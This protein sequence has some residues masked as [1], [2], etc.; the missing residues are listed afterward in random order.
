MMTSFPVCGSLLLSPLPNDL[1]F[2]TEKEKLP[3]E[4]KTRRIQKYGQERTNGSDNQ[5]D[6]GVLLRKETGID[7]SIQCEEVVANATKLPL[8]SNSYSNVVK[9]E[10]G[11]V[12]ASDNFM[13]AN[14]VKEESFSDLGK[15]ETLGALSTSSTCQEV[16]ANAMK[17]PFLS[18]SYSNVIKSE[19][20]TVRA[21]DNSMVPHKVKGESFSDLA[22]G[23]TLEALTTQEIGSVEKPCRT[24]ASGGKVLEDKKANIHSDV[25]A[26]PRK[27][28]SFKGEK[29]DCFAKVDSNISKGRKARNAEHI[30]PLEQK[31]SNKVTSHEETDMHVASGK[32][33]SSSGGV[34]KLK[35]SQSHGAQG[36]E[37]LK[38]SSRV[39]S[40]LVSKN[41][42]SSHSNYSVSKSEVEGSKFQ[43]DHGKATCA[44][45]D[46]F[47]D[48][49]EL[50]HGDHDVDS[51]EMLSTDGPKDFEAVD[52]G[53][54]ASNCT[55]KGSL[56]SKKMEKASVS[57]AYLKA[58]SNA[59]PITG[60]GSIY[61][62]APGA[63]DPLV[64]EDWVC[65]DKCQKWRLLPLGTN[66]DCLPEKWLC[67]MLDWLPGMNRCT[68]SEEE[69]TK[70]LVA[71]YQFPA[72]GSH[73]NEHGHFGGVLS[74]LSLADASRFNKKCRN[75]GFDAVPRVGKKKNRIKEVAASV[76][77]DSPAQFFNSMKSNLQGSAKSRSLNAVNQSPPANVIESQHLSKSSVMEK[78]GNKQREK[79]RLLEHHSDGGEIRSSK[80]K[81]KKETDRD[82]F[83]VSKKTKIEG[84]HHSEDW[85]PDHDGAVGKVGPTSS[86]GLSVSAL[87]NDRHKYDNHL[88]KGRRCEANNSAKGPLRNPKD[89]VLVTSDDGSLHLR[90]SD[91]DIVVRK[92]KLNENQDTHVYTTPLFNEHCLNGRRDFVEETSEND[93]R[94]GKK[95]RVSKSEGKETSVSKDSVG[96]ANNDITTKE[97]QFGTDQG[98]IRSQQSLDATDPLRRD[99][100]SSQSSQAATS[101]SSKVSG[102]NKS[103]GNLKEVK[104][105]PVESVSSSPLRFSNSDKSASIRKGLEGKDDSGDACLFPTGTPRRCSDGQD[106]K[107]SQQSH[108]IKKNE[109]FVSHRVPLEPSV[110]DFQERD[111]GHL[112]GNEAK[113]QIVLSPEFT[114]HHY[115]NGGTHTLGN[116]TEYPR[117]PQISDPCRSE[118]RGNDK[119]YHSNGRPRKSGK[120]SLSR[121]KENNRSSK[122]ELDKGNESVNHALHGEKSRAGKNRIQEKFGFSSD[123]VENNYVGT[124]ESADKLADENSKIQS[125]SIFVGNDDLDVK[126]DALSSHDQKKNLLLDCDERSSHKYLSEKTDRIEVSGRGK[127]HIIPPS[128]RVQNETATHSLHLVPGSQEENGVDSLLV[129]A[130]KR[131]SALNALKQIKKSEKQNGNQPIKSRHPTTNGHKVRDV[132]AP[133]PVRRDSSSQAATNAVKEAKDLKHLA[134]RLK[135]SGS[136]AESTGLYFQASLK[137][138]HGASLLESCNSESAKQTKMVQSMQIYSSTAKL[139]EFCAHEYEKSKDMAA[140]ALAY[141]CMEVAYMRVVYSSHASA[142]R[143]RH[144]LQTA[145]QIVPPG[146]SPSSSASDVDN[147]NGPTT[148]DKVSLAK[149]V[150][151]PQVAGNH[152]I[153]ARNRPNF[154]QLLNFAQDVSFAMEA[155]RKCRIAFAAANP[156]LE[157]T[158]CKEGIT[159]VKRAL[160]FNFQDVDG[161]LRLVRLAMEAIN[162]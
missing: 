75:I 78:H 34:K 156:R 86:S 25:S 12:R 107:G 4:S 102:S 76:N 48:N 19:K 36:A 160:D 1:I 136:N 45:R 89:Q 15:G 120:G 137:F 98:T 82:C 114:N 27:D 105:S 71:L 131:D 99:L 2:L 109:T 72:P 139:C 162:R 117:K 111:V 150:S 6:T 133:S 95:A 140:A 53:T 68:I 138:L 144:E 22:K 79:N 129:D 62:G 132:D 32:Q 77:Q 151:S 87:G 60:N 81:S 73:N 83:R 94:K 149:G 85:M 55:S 31:P 38:D 70:E 158:H 80:V 90:K 92:R 54:F 159:S 125:Q 3:G 10:K 39:D 148:L 126:V 17:H 41:R 143:Y 100:G 50:E 13:A 115:A 74:G 58:A 16:V 141:K 97:Q 37:I 106:D 130:S 14:M 61:D 118:E 153:A 142:N 124:K 11:T 26:H 96:A 66:P 64:K 84:M 42:K 128:G 152:V 8:L 30:D 146:E 56:N 20:G 116:G 135:N 5:K 43:K 113:I 7:T 57:E 145:L 121:S 40:S 21:S 93:H 52:K 9:S 147:L 157:E 29:G 47:G 23:E 103:K 35:G 44:Y 134:D 91:D 88:S 49:I 104:G 59:A 67:S 69:T 154:M 108:R 161:L 18:S 24:A 119:Q 123:R 112:A 101:N 110:L 63:V 46:F 51:V 122:S 65:C 155:S 28:G 33:H 127:S